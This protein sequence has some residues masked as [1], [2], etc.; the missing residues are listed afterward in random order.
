MR[1]IDPTNQVSQSDLFRNR[2]ENIINLEHPLAKLSREIDWSSLEKQ[3]G[4]FYVEEIGRPGIPIRVMAGL[5]YLK[6]LYN[7]SDEQVVEKYVENPYWQ[8]F[9]GREYFEHELPCHPTALVKWRK[10]VGSKGIEKMLSETIETA[11]RSGQLKRQELERVN[12][13][14]TVQEKAIAFPTDARLYHKARRALVRAAK[15]AGIKLRQSYERIGKQTLDEQARYAAAGQIKRAIKKTKKLRTLLGCVIRDVERKC[16]ELTEGLKKALETARRIFEQQRHDSHKIYS[17]HATEVECIAKGKAHKKY[18]FGCKVSAVTTSRQCWM[19]GIEARHGNPYDGATLKG[20]ISQMERLTGVKPKEVFVDRGYKGSVYHPEGVDVYLSGRR[21]LSP[22]LKRY[23]RRR[24]AIEP[25]FGHTKADHRMDRNY[26]LGV[27]GD[28]IN[29]L[30]S[31]CGWNLRK[32]W[33]I[34]F[35]FI[36]EGMQSTRVDRNSSNLPWR[37]VFCLLR[38]KSAFA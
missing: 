13:D 3:F 2:L 6:Y 23:L 37:S 34:F 35:L 4:Q 24:S 30:L 28:R 27:E 21:G 16:K 17:V 32:L 10:R 5:H 9:C 8:Y 29:A 22:R 36:L 18:E 26:L 20:A 19:V 31:A 12:V 14:T 38:M 15:R 1:P 33:R 7:E 11:K 25:V